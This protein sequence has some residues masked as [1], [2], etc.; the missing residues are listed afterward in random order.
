MYVYDKGDNLY[1]YK[2][3]YKIYQRIPLGLFSTFIE[4]KG[5]VHNF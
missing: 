3:V 5:H 2:Q 1:L 4:I